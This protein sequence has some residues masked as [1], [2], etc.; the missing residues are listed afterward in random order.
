MLAK[1]VQDAGWGQ[2]I[3]RIDDK[4]AGAGRQCVHVNPAGTTQRCSGCQTVVPKTL[5]ERWHCCSACGLSL[6]RDENAARE[7]LEAK[8]ARRERKRRAQLDRQAVREEPC[9]DAPEE[10]GAP[11]F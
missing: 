5:S 2:F 7:A 4:V 11:S 6:S 1:S 8:R 3:Q 9:L 10:C